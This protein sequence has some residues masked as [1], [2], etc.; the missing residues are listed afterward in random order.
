MGKAQCVDVH[1]QSKN[2]EGWEIESDHGFKAC[3]S[4]RE[5]IC[6]KKKNRKR[7]R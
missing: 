6:F 7:R 5:R 3:L 4:Y 2:L 1:L